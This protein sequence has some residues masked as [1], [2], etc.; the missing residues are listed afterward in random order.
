MMVRDRWGWEH[1]KAEMQCNGN[2]FFPGPEADRKRSEH[3]KAMV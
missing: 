2:K 3:A 1:N